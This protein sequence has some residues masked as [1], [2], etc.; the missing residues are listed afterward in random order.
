MGWRGGRA[1]ANT[2]VPQ[3]Q[4]RGEPAAFQDDRTNQ[5]GDSGFPNAGSAKRDLVNQRMRF[6][7]AKRDELAR[8][9]PQPNIAA[10]LDEGAFHPLVWQAAEDLWS[11]GFR[12]WAARRA[13]A[14]LAAHVRDLLG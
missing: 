7:R 4:A 11:D 5:F 8:I 6:G 10:R 13:A 1:R 3:R 14:F 9:G 12:S 2:A